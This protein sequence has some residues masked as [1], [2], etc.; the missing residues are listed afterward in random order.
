[1]DLNEEQI[2]ALQN[3]NFGVTILKDGQGDYDMS[4]FNEYGEWKMVIERFE[5]KED[6]T[7]QAKSSDIATKKCD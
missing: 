2:K 4:Q 7:Y 3:F 6:G 5:E 1:M